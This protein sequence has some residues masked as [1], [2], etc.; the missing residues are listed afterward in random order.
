MLTKKQKRDNAR[1]LLPRC[2]AT[3]EGYV[4]ELHFGHCDDGWKGNKHRQE[5][6]SWTD[7]YAK[8]VLEQAAQTVPT[9]STS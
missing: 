7:A 3:C 8:Q 6:V 9:K 4:C 1:K 2:L 5:G